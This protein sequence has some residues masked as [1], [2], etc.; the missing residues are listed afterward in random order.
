M[1]YTYL[2]STGHI[3]KSN[4]EALNF[5]NILIGELCDHTGTYIVKKG[6]I[7]VKPENIIATIETP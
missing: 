3:V 2:L 4:D 5:E 1:K 7:K 6:S